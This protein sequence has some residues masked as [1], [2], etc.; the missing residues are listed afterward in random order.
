MPVA[1]LHAALPEP[2]HRGLAAACRANF[3]VLPT[4]GVL[5]LDRCAVLLG[6]RS[7]PGNPACRFSATGGTATTR[8]YDERAGGQEDW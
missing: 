7:R 2:G 1:R 6:T 3:A 5:G 8:R 4:F